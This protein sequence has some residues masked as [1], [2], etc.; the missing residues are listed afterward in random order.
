MDG[1][2]RPVAL[3]LMRHRHQFEAEVAARVVDGVRLPRSAVIGVLGWHTQAGQGLTDELGQREELERTPC[4]L[5]PLYDEFPHVLVMTRGDRSL[6]DACNKERLAG[7]NLPAIIEVLRAIATKVQQLHAAGL[8]HGDLKQRNVIRCD[9]DWVLCDMDAAGRVGAQIGAKTSTGYGPPE[10]ACVRFGGR[11]CGGAADT[12]EAQ[13]TFDIWSIGVVGFELC[14][15]RTLFAQDTANDELVEESDRTRLCT[16]D[17][18]S[19]AELAPVLAN[20]EAGASTQTQHD[21]KHLIRLILQGDP[22]RRPSIDEVL[23]HPFLR[24]GAPP[25]RPLPMRFAN[26][27]SHAQAD[28]SGMVADLYHAFSRL[29]LHAWLDSECKITAVLALSLRSSCTDQRRSVFQC[30]RQT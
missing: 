19:D 5:H 27:L 2:G 3:K 26:F 23:N 10:L 20:A 11:R 17:V 24:L 28:A 8:V 14:A 30:G 7:Y 18:I 4:P 6:H 29:G 21:A 12:V 25:T 9:S 1:G 13:P 16:W 15:G 22:A